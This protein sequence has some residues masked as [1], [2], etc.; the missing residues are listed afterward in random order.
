MTFIERDFILPSKI[1]QVQI[2]SYKRYRGRLP[3][4]ANAH[5]CW[6][7]FAIRTV[8]NF[9]NKQIAIQTKLKQ[10]SVINAYN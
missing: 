9:I 8:N 2:H 10:C 5:Q 4:K 6:P 3:K 7:P 1:T